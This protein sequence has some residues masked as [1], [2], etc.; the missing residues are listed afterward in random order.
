MSTSRRNFIRNAG[1]LLP[2]LSLSAIS[3]KPEILQDKKLS[4]VCVGGHPDDPESGCGGTLSK[5]ANAGHQVTIIY[6]T[7][8]EAGIPGISHAEAAKIRTREAEAACKIISAQAVFAGQVD[9]DTIMNGPQK[10]GNWWNR[11][12]RISYSHTGPLIHIKT[13]RPPA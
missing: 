4:I 1:A 10:S 6:L 5:L 9:G 11:R 3:G 7:R 12:S 13:T 8:G 2:G